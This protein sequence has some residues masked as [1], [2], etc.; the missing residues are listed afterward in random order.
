MSQANASA[1]KR[2]GVP[3]PSPAPQINQQVYNQSQKQVPGQQTQPQNGFTLQQVIGIID[4]RLINLEKSL[5][6]NGSAGSSGSSQRDDLQTTINSEFNER[7]NMIALEINELKDKVSKQ[8]DDIR[9]LSQNLMDM[10]TLLIKLSS[11]SEKVSNVSSKEVKTPET[12][13]EDE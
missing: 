13:E 11:N 1:R 3:A 8:D 9:R 5:G 6:S 4:K 2:R 10:Q 7:F 12:E